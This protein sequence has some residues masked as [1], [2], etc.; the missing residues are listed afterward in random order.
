MAFKHGVYT[1]PGE[2]TNMGERFSLSF[3]NIKEVKKDHDPKKPAKDFV[4]GYHID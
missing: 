3:R 1:I 4:Y 2:L